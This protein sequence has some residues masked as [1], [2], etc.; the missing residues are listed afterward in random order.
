MH[1]TLYLLEN[2]EKISSD[3]NNIFNMSIYLL[4]FIVKG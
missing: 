3:A 1:T 4:W 2:A